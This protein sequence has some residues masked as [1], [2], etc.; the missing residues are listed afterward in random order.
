MKFLILAFM[1][2]SLMAYTG[3]RVCQARNAQAATAYG[4]M[5]LSECDLGHSILQKDARKD[6][7]DDSG[8][9]PWMNEMTKY[10]VKLATFDFEFDWSDGGSKLEN[11]R[12]VWEEF[13]Q[14]YNKEA[15]ATEAQLSKIAA[16]GLQQRLEDIALARAKKGVWTEYPD[17]ANGRGYYQV[18]FSNNERFPIRTSLYWGEY[19]PGTTPLIH[20]VILDEPGRAKRLL[21]EGADVNTISPQG[22]T[23]LDWAAAADTP[24]LLTILLRP[25]AAGKVKRSVKNRALIVAV[26]RDRLQNAKVLIRAGAD[27][28]SKNEKGQTALSIAIE[29][30][31]LAMV[32]ILRDAGAHE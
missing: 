19:E 16:S 24:V 23:A 25:G 11:W 12:I 7:R 17:E 8:H 32:K 2:S 27:V 18:I 30:Y 22:D 6:A 3:V 28:N 26:S 9:D 1:M 31:Y 29:K 20:A 15:P 5:P 21:A 4:V 14:D 10:G 13:F